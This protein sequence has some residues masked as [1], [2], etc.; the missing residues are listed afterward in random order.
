MFVAGTASVVSV[1]GLL[2]Y[3]YQLKLVY[4]SM[5]TAGTKVLRPDHYG[6]PFEEVLLDTPDGEKIHMYV[7]THDPT[8]QGY[9]AKTVMILCPNAG[10][11]GDAL[12]IVELFYKAMH[13][14]VVIYSYRGYGESSGVSDEVGLKI[15][16]D[17]V[18]KYVL[19]HSQLEKTSLILYGR[20][21]GGAVSIYIA[22][23]NFTQVKALVLENT[24][25]SI[26]KCIP[27]IFPVLS[28]FTF[29]CHQI[30][31]SEHAILKVSPDVQ[32]LF[33]CASDDEIVPPDH[34]ET[35]YETSP[36][37][38][39]SRVMFDGAHHNDTCLS[40]DYWNIVENFI[41]TIDPV[42]R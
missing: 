19:N 9:V 30:W 21:L 38:I 29:L 39:K 24:F 11:I 36:S 26:R 16:A 34:M 31:D 23:Q 27:H 18:M 42:E 17:T 41:K 15:D 35:L 28:R 37:A 20:S 22:S 7:L 33:L 12:P 32:M 2:L 8:Q 14:N 40:P 4:P 13:Y 6:M 3:K 25:L 5:L 10:T 1:L